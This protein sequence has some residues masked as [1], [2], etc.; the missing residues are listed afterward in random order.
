PKASVLSN[1]FLTKKN[2][3]IN[4][5]YTFPELDTTSDLLFKASKTIDSNMINKAIYE[6]ASKSKI[7]ET[8]KIEALLE[9][10]NQFE[11]KLFRLI[12]AL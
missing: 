11:I 6:V 9:Y 10:W 5:K 4:G 7:L 12:Q 3:I 2:E 8:N 1:F